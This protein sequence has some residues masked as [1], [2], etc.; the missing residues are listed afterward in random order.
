[1][2][3]INQAT[4]LE[5]DGFRASDAAGIGCGVSDRHRNRAFTDADSFF[6]GVAAPYE[7]G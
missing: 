3:E 4:R 2:R 6:L 7:D 1:M 5:R